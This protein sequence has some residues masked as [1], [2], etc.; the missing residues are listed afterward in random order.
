MSPLVGFFSGKQ[1]LGTAHRHLPYSQTSVLLFDPNFDPNW[2]DKCERWRPEPRH[3][4]GSTVLILRL[5]GLLRTLANGC[6]IGWGLT[7]NQPVLGSSPR[8]LTSKSNS[9]SERPS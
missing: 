1:F 7:L 3:S 2:G 9:S 6:E 5:R 4:I 8:G